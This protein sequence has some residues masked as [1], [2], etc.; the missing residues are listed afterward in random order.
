MGRNRDLF[1]MPD[2]NGCLE[3]PRGRGG[4]LAVARE[5]L[6][7]TDFR[8][9][10]G[11]AKTK[12]KSRVVTMQSA[13]VK[14]LL[15]PVHEC[16]YDFVSSRDW[17][18]RGEFSEEHALRLVEDSREGEFCISG[19][20][21]SA[22]DNFDPALSFA[23]ACEVARS[24]FLS[25]EEKE[26]IRGSFDPENLVFVDSQGR[27]GRAY[28]GQMMGNKL[29]FPLLCLINRAVWNI[30][31]QLRVNYSGIKKRRAVLI[32]GDDIAFF[33]DS[34]FFETWKSVVS[35]YGMVLNLE[36]TGF[37]PLYIELNSKSFYVPK[38]RF[39]SKP[40]LSFFRTT[41]TPGC[42]LQQIFEGAF[43]LRRDVFWEKCVL[44]MRHHI[45]RKGVALSSVPRRFLKTL[46]RHK[47]FRQALTHPPV[48]LT[49]SVPRMEP[50][51]V[52]DYGPP[53]SVRPVFDS[54]S[55]V[56]LSDVASSFEGL[57]L[58][59]Y[60]EKVYLKDLG[61]RVVE[62]CRC[63]DD[64]CFDACPKRRT[65]L[66]PLPSFSRFVV[67]RPRLCWLWPV[68]VL[69]YW[70]RAGFPV[71]P[72]RSSGGWFDDHPSVSITVDLKRVVTVPPPRCLRLSRG[73]LLGTVSGAKFLG[74]SRQVH[75]LA[76]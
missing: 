37:S 4:T 53:P 44:P 30:S 56:V 8:L 36:K 67:G 22:T 41:N 7:P 31:H 42:T 43:V 55:R 10:L 62:S 64:R 68:R 9:R 65:V 50:V 69:D 5:D 1:L 73:A 52:R 75:P 60:T 71:E 49:Y 51:V 23:V 46:F 66:W 2:Q 18:V 58:C 47:W 74:L 24:R 25:P 12:G 3:K 45:A 76:A 54:L 61:E 57:D 6:D 19:D 26:C 63:G 39:V 59:R 11:V 72:V 15:S 35:H 33:G 13:G 27:V 14:R 20:F 32:N 48:V 17:I 40:V 38:R 28:R 16:L 70:E 34:S 21:S 29:S